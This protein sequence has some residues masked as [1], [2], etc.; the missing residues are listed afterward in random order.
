MALTKARIAEN[1]P[2]HGLTLVED[3]VAMGDEQDPL[4]AGPT[5]S[6]IVKGR[7]PG[8]PSARWGDDQVLVMASH[9]LG[10]QC[11]KDG[12]LER[13]RCWR[14]QTTTGETGTP[15]IAVCWSSAACSLS[16]ST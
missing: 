15:A 10:G 6:L 13:F 14:L 3:L 1:R 11:V 5:Q 9:A 12:Q 2:E 8:L 16:P 7:N 4:V